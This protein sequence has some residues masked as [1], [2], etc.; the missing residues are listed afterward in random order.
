MIIDRI[1]D[2]YDGSDYNA[3]D[4][5]NE[6]LAYGGYGT[7]I[8]RA[9]DF[10]SEDDVRKALCDYIDFNQYNRKIKEFINKANWLV[11]DNGT[12]W[13]VYV[14]ILDSAADENKK[15]AE[16]LCNAIKKFAENPGAIDNFESYLSNHFDVWMNEYVNTPSGLVSE[17]KHFSEIK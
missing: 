6:M 1:L 11:D 5:Y 14:Q 4:F 15:N 10:G 2:R 9:M 7:N 13:C 3:K 8:S 12:D 16:I 17:F